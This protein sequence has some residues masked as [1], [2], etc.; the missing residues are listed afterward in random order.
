MESRQD[1]I[2]FL[3][4]ARVRADDVRKL[5][6]LTYK[7]EMQYKEYT[8][9]YEDESRAVQ[10]SINMT[11]KK[12]K[13][14]LEK[15]FDVEIDKADDML[16]AAHQERGK[17]KASRQKDRIGRETRELR[18]GIRRFDNEARTLFKQE[19]IP[20]YC[21]SK[22]FLALT[23][24]SGLI[25]VLIC[26][27]C[28]AVIFA[29]I[30]F[31]LINALDLSASVTALIYIAEIIVFGFI[32]YIFFLRYKI[33]HS[34]TINQA[35]Q[36]RKRIKA[37]EKQINAIKQNIIHDKN[38]EMYDLGGYDEQISNIEGD[39][40]EV[41]MMKRAALDD[42]EHNTKVKIT[43][44]IN[45]NNKQRLEDLLNKSNQAKVD[46]DEYFENLQ[47][48]RLDLAR[49]YET[50]LGKDYTDEEIDAYIAYLRSGQATNIS[51][52]Q[53]LYKMG[54]KIGFDV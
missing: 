32:Y 37:D 49:D 27:L 12:R 52:A 50:V 8:K 13:S 21:G 36:I 46:Y 45:L 20:E 39:K 30:P 23:Y 40:N 28:F 34:D 9:Q 24:P 48:M 4:E 16:K 44:E 26:A 14:E 18:D 15:S 47:S 19:N 3:E 2:R 51:E 6:N 35:R 7:K 53:S 43:N 22:F 1:Q 17:A 38:E 54:A 5:A 10:D 41:G 29:I 31:V 33:L 25:D 42:F 11:I